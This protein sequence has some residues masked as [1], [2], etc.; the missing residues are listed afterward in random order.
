[1]TAAEKPVVELPTPSTRAARNVLEALHALLQISF[2]GLCSA[3]VDVRS[4]GRA[5]LV[6]TSNRTGLEVARWR[7]RR[8]DVGEWVWEPVRAYGR[9]E[10]DG[11]G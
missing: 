8:D 9:S 2:D 1:M 10:E 4:D 3:D 7:F 5:Q 6:F 11:N